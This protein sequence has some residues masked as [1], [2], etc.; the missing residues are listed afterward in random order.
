MAVW[1]SVG[2]MM[3]VDGLHYRPDGNSAVCTDGRRLYNRAL[4]G[5]HSG[6]RMECGDVPVFGIYLPGMGGHLE[7][8]LPDGVCTARYTPGRM[9][10][11]QGVLR[12]RLRC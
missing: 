1:M 10:Y 6:F 7:F 12:C 9:D 3:A 11:E 2:P 5:A 4:Y 8:A